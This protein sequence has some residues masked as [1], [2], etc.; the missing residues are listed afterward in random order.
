M[1]LFKRLFAWTRSLPC[2]WIRANV[3]SSLLFTLGLLA[4][5]LY[6][7]SGI[8]PGLTEFRTL[9]LSLPVIWVFSLAVRIAAQHLAIGSDSLELETRLGPTGNLS[10]DYEFLRP[11]QILRYAMAGHVATL[12]LVALGF[13][14]SSAVSP[15]EG[16][17]PSLAAVLD[18]HG[19]WGSLAWATQIFWVN[20]LI[21]VLN[22]L[23]TIP[24]DNRALLY[25][26]ALLRK[27]KDESLVLRN[28]ASFDSHLACLL[29]GC[30]FSL[31]ATAIF[32]QWDSPGWYALMAVGIYLFVASRWELTRAARLEQ[33]CV[34]LSESS[35]ERHHH[36]RQ[37]SL[38]HRHRTVAFEQLVHSD[39]LQSE[40]HQ[41][42][43]SQ[44][45]LQERRMHV[46]DAYLDDILRKLHREGAASLS[47]REQEALL[48]ASQKLKEKHRTK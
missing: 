11:Q 37:H 3:H 44:V 38:A 24:F 39:S 45:V 5:G 30:G 8:R 10:T 25:S 41:S 7:L 32:T 14:V 6:V 42:S 2:H 47:V 4:L 28:L 34:S 15:V 20:V 22:F 17:T 18:I 26:I 21:A 13:F 35:R 48:T 9:T 46:S 31:L 19:G 29:I 43:D 23:P 1:R 33:Q 16:A 36:T 40:H 27:H 12:F